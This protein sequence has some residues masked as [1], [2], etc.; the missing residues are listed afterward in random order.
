MIN[1]P[2]RSPY[3]HPEFI[4]SVQRV[5]FDAE[6]DSVQVR[7]REHEATYMFR[8]AREREEGVRAVRGIMCA[9]LFMLFIGIALYLG[10]HGR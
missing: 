3:S 6:S 2:R 4:R 7:Q 5:P 8:K 1:Q 9:F 10:V